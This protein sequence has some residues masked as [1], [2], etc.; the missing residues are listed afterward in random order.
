M[1]GEVRRGL[2]RRVERDEVGLERDG[3]RNWEG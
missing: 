1:R 3:D 2:R